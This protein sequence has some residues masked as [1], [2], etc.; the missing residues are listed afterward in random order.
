MNDENDEY[1]DNGNAGEGANEFV[2][3]GNGGVEGVNEY[4][5]EGNYV[6]MNDAKHN[7]NKMNDERYGNGTEVN[8][9]GNKTVF[10]DNF[11]INRDVNGNH[12]GGDRVDGS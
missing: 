1:A 6:D 2:N 3:D 9:N 10:L 12:E 7:N 8:K 11:K 5:K 4:M